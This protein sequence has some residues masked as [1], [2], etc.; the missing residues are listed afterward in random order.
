MVMKNKTM[1]ANLKRR[2]AM[3]G[4]RGGNSTIEMVFAMQ[5]LMFICMGMVEFGQFFYIKHAFEAAARDAARASILATAT[6]TSPTTAATYTLSEANVTFNSAWLTITDT[7]T[8]ATVTDVSTIAAG[9]ILQVQLKATYD[10]I[11]NVM[12][13]LYA[14]TGN[15]FGIKNGK[16]MLGQCTMVRE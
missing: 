7:T 4:H 5:L 15:N 1:A 11:P 3:R 13:P 6:S 10:Q 12:R 9:D 2:A 16:Q 8:G 14:I